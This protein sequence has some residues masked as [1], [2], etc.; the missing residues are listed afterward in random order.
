[1]SLSER[2]VEER[3]TCALHDFTEVIPDVP[4]T[5]WSSV[6]RASFAPRRH[7]ARLLE[8]AASVIVVALATIV[9][10]DP[11]AG[12]RFHGGVAVRASHS[13]SVTL[14]L[15]QSIGDHAL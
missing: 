9:W 4:P 10:A 14:P 13:V 7:T 3:V 5:P 6:E 8:I 12:A 2:Q 15:P 11:S 1:M